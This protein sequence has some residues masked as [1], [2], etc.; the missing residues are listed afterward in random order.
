MCTRITLTLPLD[1]LAQ[2]F[3]DFHPPEAWHP[4]YNL[5]PG[6][7]VLAV[8]NDGSRR[9]RPVLWGW[10]RPGGGTGLLVNARV[11]TVAQKPTFR[12]AFRTRRC[13]VLADGFYEWTVT[14]GRKQPWRITRRDGRPFALAGLWMEQD[15]EPRCVVLTTE[16]RPPVTRLHPRMPVVL[17]QA[18]YAPWLAPGALTAT[19][20]TWLERAWEPEAWRVYPVHPRVNTT[21]VDDPSCILPYEPPQPQLPGLDVA[22]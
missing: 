5:G 7:P 12:E 2:A 14:G 22:S 17:P 3:P 10:P 8:L 15:G 9:M 4:R 20:P 21:R 13:L 1:A 6:Q 11:E 19:W 18:A 16:A